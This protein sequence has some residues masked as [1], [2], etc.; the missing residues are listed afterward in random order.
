MALQ[1][2]QDL[3]DVLETLGVREAVRQFAPELD[4][5]AVA[6]ARTMGL[7]PQAEATTV[8]P[9][10]DTGTRLALGGIQ[11]GGSADSVARARL[12]LLY[13][14]SGDHSLTAIV[15]SGTPEPG[16]TEPIDGLRVLAWIDF[17]ARPAPVSGSAA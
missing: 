13:P 3:A 17:P 15:F 12:A 8:V 4:E 5:A 7:Q 6:L 14:D 9:A 2:R 11:L 16:S 10:V 1:E